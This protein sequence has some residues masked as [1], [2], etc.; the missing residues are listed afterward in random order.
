V[1][2][3]RPIHVGMI[4]LDHHVSGRIEID[5]RRRAGI[6]LGEPD[7]GRDIIEDARE[8]DGK[9]T[10]GLEERGATTVVVSKKRGFGVERREG[11]DEGN[12][13]VANQPLDVFG[14]GESGGAALRERLVE[15]LSGV[16]RRLGRTRRKSRRRRHLILR[17]GE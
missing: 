16:L 10:V 5:Q 14:V 12:E 17:G 7:H 11:L 1:H 8:E 6:W 15:E 13:V 9:G 2:E 3:S 4:W